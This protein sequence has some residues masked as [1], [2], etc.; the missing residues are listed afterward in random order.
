LGL[1]SFLQKND[2]ERTAEIFMR[3]CVIKN[4]MLS[5]RRLLALKKP[6]C[7]HLAKPQNVRRQWVTV[8]RT[9]IQKLKKSVILRFIKIIL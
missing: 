6:R 7:L 2:N 1:D 9:M 8:H 5:L 4:F 3:L